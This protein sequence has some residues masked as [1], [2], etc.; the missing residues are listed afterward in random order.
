MLIK[1]YASNCSSCLNTYFFTNQHGHN[2]LHTPAPKIVYGAWGLKL[3]F[4]CSSCDKSHTKKVKKNSNTFLS[5]TNNITPILSV[6]KKYKYV[7]V[8][9][10]MFVLLWLHWTKCRFG[11]FMILIEKLLRFNAV[12]STNSYSLATILRLVLWPGNAKVFCL[13]VRSIM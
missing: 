2:L 6:Y 3:Q 13:F 1:Y 10:W 8:K 12:S 11:I 9:V 7:D 5:Y 4:K